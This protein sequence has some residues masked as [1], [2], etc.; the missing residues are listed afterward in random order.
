[1]CIRHLFRDT[2]NLWYSAKRPWKKRSRGGTTGYDDIPTSYESQLN[3]LKNGNREKIRKAIQL[4]DGCESKG[5]RISVRENSISFSLDD[6]PEETLPNPWHFWQQQ[7][8][9]FPTKPQFVCITHGDMQARNLLVDEGARTWLIDFQRTGWGSG[10]RD[11]AELESAIKFDLLDST[12]LPAL[13][14]F[15]REALDCRNLN[16]RIATHRLPRRR[17]RQYQMFER[18]RIAIDS[19]RHEVSTAL[20][21]PPFEEYLAGLFFY[22]IKMLTF[23]DVT[24]GV[25]AEMRQERKDAARIHMLYSAARIC[26]LLADHHEQSRSR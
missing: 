21:H 2:C 10:L 3:L 18:A 14:R 13:L 12:N 8:N 9:C 17:A 16:E 4:L 26:K 1:M 11:A 7:R 6:E 23:D 15:E 5:I 24:T 19:I 25:S 20:E 22:A